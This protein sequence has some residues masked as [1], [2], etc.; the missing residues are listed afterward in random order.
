LG[1]QQLLDKSPSRHNDVLRRCMC[2]H[3]RACHGRKHPL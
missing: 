1:T 3:G 2:L